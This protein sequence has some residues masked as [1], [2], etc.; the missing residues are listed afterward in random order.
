[1]YYFFD[2]L[3][4]ETNDDPLGGFLGSMRLLTDDMPAD[5]AYWEDWMNSV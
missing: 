1:M 5:S 3:Y 4:E 2:H